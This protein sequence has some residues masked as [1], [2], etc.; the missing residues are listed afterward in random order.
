MYIYIY[1]YI[2]TCIYVYSR[3]LQ[4]SA[5]CYI[6]WRA[7]VHNSQVTPAFLMEVF[8]DFLSPYWLM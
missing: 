3:G 1:M 5:L 8:V 6:Y 4:W 7:Q 2:Y